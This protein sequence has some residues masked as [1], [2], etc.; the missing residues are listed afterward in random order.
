ML[1]QGESSGMMV[2]RSGYQLQSNLACLHHKGGLYLLYSGGFMLLLRCAAQ[3]R[4]IRGGS[5]LRSGNRVTGF[6]GCVITRHCDNVK[7][8]N[9]GSELKYCCS[10]LDGFFL[11]GHCGS[12]EARHCWAG[13]WQGGC[14]AF[15]GMFYSGSF[16]GAMGESSQEFCFFVETKQISGVYSDGM[17]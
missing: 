5:G 6:H 8:S 10:I 14:A 3:S 16:P 1:I 4:Q 7:L 12:Q 13:K 9:S 17:S 11:D 15:F 2:S